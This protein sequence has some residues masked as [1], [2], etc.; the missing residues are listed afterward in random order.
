MVVTTLERGR[1]MSVRGKPEHTFYENADSLRERLVRGFG[2]LRSLPGVLRCMKRSRVWELVL[3]VTGLLVLVVGIGDAVRGVI[4]HSVSVYSWVFF[5]LLCAHVLVLGV[6]M[7]RRTL[8]GFRGVVND[9]RELEGGLVQDFTAAR[10]RREE[11]NDE[12][13][14]DLQD[15]L[16]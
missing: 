16:G 9:R 4:L 14:V 13:E 5:G 3:S 6:L 8:G 15:I 12:P 11:V 2:V 7:S 10:L 1:L